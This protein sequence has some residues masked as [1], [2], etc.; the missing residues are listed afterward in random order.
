MSMAG[1]VLSPTEKALL[2]ILKLVS[3]CE[4]HLDFPQS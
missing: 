3:S 4:A 2:F 1:R